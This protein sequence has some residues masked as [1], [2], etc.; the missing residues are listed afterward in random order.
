MV[1]C[2]GNIPKPADIMAIL[3]ELHADQDGCKF[4]YIVTDTTGCVRT[5]KEVR[6]VSKSI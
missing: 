1:E 6:H 5:N 4:E 3:L 2:V